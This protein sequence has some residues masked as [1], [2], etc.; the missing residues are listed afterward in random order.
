VTSKNEKILNEVEHVMPLCA[1]DH[2]TVHDRGGDRIE[3]LQAHLQADRQFIVRQVGNRHLLYKNKKRSFKYLM[4]HTELP[5][6]LT[7][8]RIHKNKV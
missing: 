6:T 2:I 4:R 1:P 7:V 8:E 5:W 3:V